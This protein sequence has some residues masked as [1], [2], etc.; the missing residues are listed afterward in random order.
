M[1][2][3]F[4]TDGIRGVANETLDSA[5]A[6]RVGL[7]TAITLCKITD[8]NPVVMMGKDT[9]ISS[10][11]LESA[12][13][14]GLCAGGAEVV[15]VGEVPTPAVA[16][17][18]IFNHADAG[19]M[20]SAS[21]NSYEYNGIKI[22]S[23][24]GFKLTDEL[25]ADIETLVLSS[26]KLPTKTGGELGQVH[27]GRHGS[28]NYIHHL[29]STVDEDISDL[30]VLFDCSNGSATKTAARIFNRF[31]IL[32]SFMNDQPNG[33]NINDHCGSTHMENL[34]QRVVKGCYDLG[35][36]FD[37]DADRCLMVDEKGNEIDG[38]QI[39]AVCALHLKK[40]GKLKKDGFV[41]T[42]MSNL[43]LHKFAER[44]DMKL[45]CASV[46][47]KNVLEMMRERS[48]NLGG[49]QSGH[50]IFLDHMTTGDGQLSAL[51]FLQILSNTSTKA[52]D[53]VSTID[54]FPQVLLGVK[55]PMAMKDKN[56]VM[57]NPQ[58]V[59]AIAKAQTN[60]GSDGRVLV[61]ASGT[62]PLIR[63]MVE[64]DTLEKA[65]KIA[66]ELVE[67]VENAQKSL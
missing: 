51:Q 26:V 46:G 67:N 31:N 42:V 15:C 8:K 29:H 1:G 5:L 16:Y 52:S 14:A 62:E 57:E 58:L 41:A 9:R 34:R 47:D 20:I 44:E 23:G 3:L 59:E 18:T 30:R 49:E 33:V 63:V 22:F 2:K 35:V 27:N 24:T 6:Y 64:A 17:L 53:L 37:G 36:A 65:S 4:G 13:C 54:Q 38:D 56:A 25:E 45:L 10:D 28:E 32:A 21:H 55:G 50:V 60:L 39:L 61:R 48:M 43:G 7:A 66:N 40:K 11:M 19:I 12:L